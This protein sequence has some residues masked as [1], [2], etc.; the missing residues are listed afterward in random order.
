MDIIYGDQ[1]VTITEDE[2]KHIKLFQHSRDVICITNADTI[3]TFPI[4]L[5]YI[6]MWGNK[7]GC[8][9]VKIE[10]ISHVIMEKV[11]KQCD[12]DLISSHI[13]MNVPKHEIVKQLIPLITS[14]VYLNVES[15]SKKIYAYIAITLQNSSISDIASATSDP[16][17]VQLRDAAIQEWKEANSGNKILVVHKTVGS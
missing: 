9:Y 3:K 6:R 17:Y 5:Q 11:L 7:P 2:I 10:K 14:C 8:D 4:I 1:R 13:D 12:I 15:F 16:Q